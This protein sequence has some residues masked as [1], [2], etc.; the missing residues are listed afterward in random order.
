LDS[1]FREEAVEHHSRRLYGEVIISSPIKS[2]VFTIIICAVVTL[3]IAG[4]VFGSL[5]RKESVDGRLISTNGISSV[6]ASDRMLIDQV[7]VGE[8][9]LVEKDDNLVKLRSHDT[10]PTGERN[11]EIQLKEITQEKKNLTVKLKEL[12]SQLAS[13]TSLHD[14]EGKRI[15]EQLQSS[16]ALQQLKEDQIQIA[17]ASVETSQ[18]LLEKGLISALDI[19]ARQQ[20]LL[21]LMND[22]E[23]LKSE[24]NSLQSDLEK[25]PIEYSSKLAA[26]REKIANTNVALSLTKQKRTELAAKAESL[27]TAPYAGR[28]VALQ[29]VPGEYSSGGQLLVSVQPSESELQ[30]ELLVP[31]NAAGFLKVGQKVKLLYDAFPFQKFGAYDARI[32]QITQTTIASTLI[33][34]SKTGAPTA[35]F[36][37]V[38]SLDAQDINAF[39]TSIPLKP[40][41]TLRADLILEDRAVWE[42]IFEPIIAALKR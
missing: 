37:V 25:L 31:T 12:T 22:L 10:L 34:N 11:F 32:E 5:S 18:P 6:I 40:G 23:I 20:A 33:D 36:R 15:A 38:A 9:Q 7:Y 3:G 42:V 24:Q 35:A 21:T 16:K 14:I 2:R 4:L 39:D 41:M 17:R 26:I 30:A 8:G 19:Q 28:V 29:A 27:Y 1:L 13:L